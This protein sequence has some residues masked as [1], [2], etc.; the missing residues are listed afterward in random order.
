[1]A[2]ISS[3]SPR[4]VGIIARGKPKRLAFFESV[5]R[6]VVTDPLDCARG[7]CAEA[8]EGHQLLAPAI[9][10]TYSWGEQFSVGSTVMMFIVLGR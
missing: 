7:D 1:M 9:D 10:D 6:D 5:V 4:V 2:C 8:V 3:T